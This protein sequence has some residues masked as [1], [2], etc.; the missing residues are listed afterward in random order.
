[1]IRSCSVEGECYFIG[2]LILCNVKE[3]VMFLQEANARVPVPRHGARFDYLKI[4]ELTI[5]GQGRLVSTSF[6]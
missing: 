4:T 6:L 5:V 3:H 2:S 1:M